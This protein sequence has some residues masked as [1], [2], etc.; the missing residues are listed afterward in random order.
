MNYSHIP[1]KVNR[2]EDFKATPYIGNDLLISAG[3]IRPS[4]KGLISYLP[5]G[6]LVINN[7][8]NL[9]N[10]EMEK[11]GGMEINTPLI[12]PEAL[13]EQTGRNRTDSM[14]IG[15]FNDRDGRSMILSPTHEEAVTSLL[16]DDI[17]SHKDLPLF[18]F[19]NQL[20]YRDEIRPR[21]Y[22]IRSREF[23]MH[24]GYSFHRNF[25]E[26]NNFFPKI[27]K[28]YKGI[29]KECGI[30]FITNE[31]DTGFMHGSRSYEFTMLHR[32]GKNV[33]IQCPHCGYRASQTIAHSE[34]AVHI[35]PLK[36]MSELTCQECER[37]E[38]RPTHRAKCKLFR[39]GKR[40]VMAIYRED[41]KLSKDKLKKIASLNEL[42]PA[43]VKET[44]GLGL[45]PQS[46]SPFNI[47][48]SVLLVVDDSIVK[49]T[50][51][52]FPSGAE[53]YCFSHVNFGR[54][55]DA[56]KIGD[57]V[58]AGN[59]DSCSICGEKMESIR[60]IELAHIF[61]LNDF[62]SEK[63]SLT[64]QDKDNR[65][66]RPFMGSYG[67]G[68]GRLLFAIADSNRDEK[69]LVWPVKLAPFHYYLMGIGKS[70][71][72]KETIFKLA[73]KMG[74][75]VIV[76]DRREGIGVKLR[77]CDMLGIPLRIII[78]KRFLEKGEVEVYKRLDSSIQYIEYKNLLNHLNEWEREQG[79][80]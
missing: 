26:L 47:S 31:A 75:R 29:L 65:I 39:S 57:I 43:T 7:L 25:T 6:K 72:I 77:D 54:D 44:R 11:L 74:K 51:L 64:F 79:I 68:L 20:K 13:W 35:E 76:D 48:S 4:G 61:K 2:A 3:Y 40:F 50:N 38:K 21:G 1:G 56:H 46:L 16:K 37:N 52:I 41:F 62:Y 14:E 73:E 67:I 19:Q 53:G 59:N 80:E 12:A 5:L 32:S 60:G 22:L 34:K 10:E 70:P 8:I 69:G 28:A 27:F 58:R 36:D 18:V 33:I 42:T 45:D 78:S 24:D 15:R 66:K 71:A 49:S 9:I 17:K 63:F 30:E 23:M 55:F